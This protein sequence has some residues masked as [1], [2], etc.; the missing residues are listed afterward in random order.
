MDDDQL[1]V[2]VFNSQSRFDYIGYAALARSGRHTQC[3]NVKYLE[4]Q[5]IAAKSAR[6]VFVQLDGELVGQLPMRFE[7]VP[8]ALRVIAAD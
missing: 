4:A 1:N 3:A 6:E 2:C 8:H 7:I 5:S